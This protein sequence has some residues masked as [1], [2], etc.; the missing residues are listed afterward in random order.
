MNIMFLTRTS[1]LLSIA[2]VSAVCSGLPAQAQTLEATPLALES[3]EANVTQSDDSSA[4]MI[5]EM[6]AVSQDSEAV[7]QSNGPAIAAEAD[8]VEPLAS[9]PGT[10]M[11]L[12]SDTP[13]Q[14][15]VSATEST[16]STS[17]AGLMAPSTAEATP[18]TVAQFGVPDPIDDVDPGQATVS[19]SSYIGLGVGV[20]FDEADPQLAILSKL[21]LTNRLSVRPSVVTDFNDATFRIPATL[22]FPALASLGQ[23]GIAP[24]IGGGLAVGVG[25]DT[26]V[27]PMVTAGVDVPLTSRFTGTAAFNVDFLNDTDFGAYVGIGYNFSGLGGLFPQ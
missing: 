23:F 9:T 12:E 4:I 25:D 27:G 16:P 26:D 24:Y 6:D 18:G 7:I 21:G 1:V 10:N 5:E 20:D 14:T 15:Q 13:D 11:P 22:D 2:V 17:A 8:P 3:S 19:S